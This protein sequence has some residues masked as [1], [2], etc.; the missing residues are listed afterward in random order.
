MIKL[1]DAPF[2]FRVTFR[3]GGEAAVIYRRM[4]DKKSKE[5]LQRIVAVSPQ[6]FA[7]GKGLFRAAVKDLSGNVKEIG[8]DGHHHPLD[9]DWGARIACFGF[10]AVGLAD[11]E[12]IYRAASNLQHT[13]GAEAAWWL[14][15]IWHSQTSR[16]VRALRI[17]VGA[18]GKTE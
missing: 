18:V 12:K 5:T 16:P 2:S 6:S 15:K 7:A 9:A 8:S 13:D 17:L 10:V 3:K 4:L 14:G 1:K 11:P